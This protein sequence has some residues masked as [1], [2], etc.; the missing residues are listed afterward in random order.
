MIQRKTVVAVDFDGTLCHS[1]FPNCG[2]PNIKLIASLK[3]I[4]DKCI[5]ILW[6]CRVG[7][8]LEIALKWSKDQGLNF[9]YANENCQQSL[10]QYGNDCRK[11]LADVY[12]DDRS[13]L[14]ENFEVEF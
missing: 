3:L 5:L 10:D 2:E 1:E 14:P 9:K 13:V 4:Q 8:A 6:T 7:A 11:I 12:I